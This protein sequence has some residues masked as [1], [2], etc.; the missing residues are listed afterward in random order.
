VIWFDLLNEPIE[1]SV[2]HKHPSYPP[3]WPEWAQ[4]TINE[5]RKIDKKHPIVVEPGPGML[6]WGFKDFPPLKDP[7]MDVIYSFHH[8]QPFEYT[9]QGVYANKKILAYPGATGDSGGGFWDA[10]RFEQE[11]APAIEFQKKYGVRIWIGEFSVVRWAPDAEQ[12]LKDSIEFFEKHGWDWSYHSLREAYEWRL[13]EGEQALLVRTDKD[14]KK[15]PFLAVPTLKL[16][17]QGFEYWPWGTPA[18]PGE[19]P[20][21]VKGLTGRGRVVLHYLLR[22]QKGSSQPAK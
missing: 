1:W 21:P 19:N 11:M 6:C 20:K 18:P 9:H 3:K 2:V 4:K 22:N 13:T 17:E 16:S 10:K 7:C 8:Y 5:I 14:G 15:V 12:W